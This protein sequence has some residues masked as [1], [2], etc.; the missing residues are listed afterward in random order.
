MRRPVVESQ[1]Q[2][3]VDASLAELVRRGSDSRLGITD[4][5]PAVALATAVGPGFAATGGSG[6][7][8]ML[9]SAST[10]RSAGPSP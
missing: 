5:G 8:L 10:S 6:S 4:A 2:A 7:G 9:L 1:A 3:S